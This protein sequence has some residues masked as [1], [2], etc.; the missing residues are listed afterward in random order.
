MSN[1]ARRLSN[2]LIL[3]MFNGGLD[4]LTIAQR[5][6]VP[7]HAIYNRLSRLTGPFQDLLR[8]E[9]NRFHG[10]PRGPEFPSIG[11]SP[12]SVAGTEKS[13]DE[14]RKPQTT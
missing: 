2:A 5:F 6:A 4:T 12:S 8:E 7:E 11:V 1:E 13:T 9:S 14:N 3:D 10:G